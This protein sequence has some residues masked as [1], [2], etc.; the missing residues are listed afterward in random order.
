MGKGARGLEP[1]PADKSHTTDNNEGFLIHGSNEPTNYEGRNA[2]DTV[3]GWK[4][5]WGSPK[6][7]DPI[8]S[9]AF[10]EDQ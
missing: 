5:N 8:P 4:Q 9:P 2:S 3:R 10:G 1:F 7:T 6:H